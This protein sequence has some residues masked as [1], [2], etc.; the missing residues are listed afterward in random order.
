[1]ARFRSVYLILSFLSLQFL[2][3]AAVLTPD[4]VKLRVATEQ[5]NIRE[6]PDITSVILLQVREGSVLEAEGKEGE[7]Y[8]VRIEQPEGTIITGYVH[9]SLVTVI[10][11][12]QPDENAV[13]VKEKKPPEK[14]EPRAKP[15]LPVPPQSLPPA[16]SPPPKPKPEHFSLSVWWGARRAGV[17][18]LNEG[19]K[20]LAELYASDLGVPF[21]GKVKELHTG[22]VAGGEIQL[23]L[24]SNFYFAAGA[25]YFST[26]ASSTITFS[27]KELR[28]VYLTT[29]GARAI[30]LSLSVLFYP[31]RFFNLR[32]GLEYSL[33]RCSFLYRFENGDQWEKWKGKANSSF[34]GYHLGLGTDWALSRHVS[35]VVEGIY[36]R[37]RVTGFEGEG[38]YQHS[39]GDEASIKGKLY[40]FEQRTAAGKTVSLLFL[41]QSEPAGPEVSE[42]KEAELDLAGVSLRIG[43]K[44][45]I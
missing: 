31:V 27:Q 2:A 30:P 12:P 10:E 33:V 13:A 43:L 44:L 17:G 14:P 5:A 9:E 45:K 8:A 39:S 29:P 36:R 24:G 7:W 23:P 3:F 25:E 6:K 37:S 16:P 38:I 26:E 40:F 19:A 41:R 21:D 32:A 34:L 15:P 22:F 11:P 42:A 20:G 35:L 18:D 28:P 1:M 4:P